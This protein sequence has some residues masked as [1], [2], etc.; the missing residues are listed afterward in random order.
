[1]D[2]AWAD[3]VIY[4]NSLHHVPA[5]VQNKAIAETARV[6][7]PGGTLCIVEPV[8]R[9]AAY[10]LFQPVE[11]ESAVYAATYKLILETGNGTEFQ[12]DR[13]ELFVDFYSYQDFEDFLDEVLVVD[14]SRAETLTRLTDML[15]QRFEQLGESAEA[16]RRYDQLHRLNLLHRS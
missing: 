14:E 3:V 16:G 9:G 10:E 12:Q 4:Y 2:D 15:R 13:E 5:D 11:D 7:V 6:L 1:M 8:A